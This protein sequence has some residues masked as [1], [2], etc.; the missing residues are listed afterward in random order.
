MS[1]S[2]RHRGA[3][4]L[5]A[6]A[7]ML[8]AGCTPNE[9][10]L[11]IR[12][13]QALP[14]DT[15]EVEADPSAPFNPRGV[16]DV[17][18]AAGY[19]CSLLVGNQLVTRGDP[20]RLR[21]ETSRV[22]IYSAEVTLMNSA[23]GS[24]G[25]STRTTSGFVDPSTGAEPGYGLADVLMIDSAPAVG[26]VVVQVVLQGRTLGG[27]E[28]TTAPWN[29]PIHVCN[30]CLCDRSTCGKAGDPAKNCHVGTDALVDCRLNL[31]GCP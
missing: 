17:A 19:S 20:D 12:Q 29:F 2:L 5:L 14:A 26:D 15:C 4:F 13:C 6:T 11:F 27:T 7:A 8:A 31:P 3:F 22:Q 23:G 10:S 9:S 30:G 25:Q 24:L 16:L 1:G 18:F 28:L 21:T